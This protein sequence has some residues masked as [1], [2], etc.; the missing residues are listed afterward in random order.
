MV[1]RVAK[2]TN[3]AGASAPTDEYFAYSAS[4]SGSYDLTVNYVQ[5]AL[6]SFADRNVPTAIVPLAR[7]ERELPDL[8]APGQVLTVDSAGTALEYATPTVPVGTGDDQKLIRLT[9]LP[10]ITGYNVGD[11]INFNGVLYELVANTD[12]ANISVSYTHLTLPTKRIV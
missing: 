1:Y 11:L 8:G 9:A 5:L 3:V 10:A 4:V 6:E 2:A 12:D 7:Q